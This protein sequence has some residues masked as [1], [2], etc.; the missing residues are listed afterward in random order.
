[1][2]AKPFDID[3]LAFDKLDGSNI[4]MEYSHNRGFYKFGTRE[5]MFDSKSEIFG[6]VVPLF[7]EQYEKKIVEILKQD[8]K[9]HLNIVCYFEVHGPKSEFGQ[10]D[11][12]NDVFKL[13]LLDVDLY[14]HGI[15][16][17]YT[18]VDKFKT[19]DIPKIVYQGPLTEEFIT[20]VKD[21]KYD[22][23][24]GVV[25][26]GIFENR[27]HR[28]IL[29]HSKIKTNDWLDRL[30]LRYLKQYNKEMLDIQ[31]ETR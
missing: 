26:K 11:F 15:L 29:Y 25:C 18:F 9:K 1:M 20:N 16:D 10:H 19:C 27:K 23:K 2:H 5:T 21:N 28:Q 24:E 31:R 30:K 17:P 4:R 3:V 6:F 14:K 22:L 12:E 8:F 7:K 13:T